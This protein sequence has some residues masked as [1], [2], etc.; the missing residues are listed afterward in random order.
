MEVCL[1][2]AALAGSSQTNIG[3]GPRSQRNETGPSA[4]SARFSRDGVERRPAAST[5]LVFWSGPSRRD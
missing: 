4:L 3:A 1:G 2:T 5:L